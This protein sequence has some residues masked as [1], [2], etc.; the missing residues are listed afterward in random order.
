[1]LTRLFLYGCFGWC[2]EIVWT[3]L[4]DAVVAWRRGERVDP[5]LTGHSYLWV[6]PIYGGGGVLFE[7]VHGLVHSA[8]WLLRGTVYMLGC[9]GV[10][11][12]TG[13]LIQRATGQI[14]WD[15]SAQRW[16]VRGLIRLDYAPV[17]FAFGLL[18]ERVERFVRAAAPVL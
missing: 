5:R 2:A 11:Y 4:T 7:V 3:A 18:L 6:L 12:A 14:P 17:W 10:E 1:M 9:F 16:H 8:P 15:Y 13:W